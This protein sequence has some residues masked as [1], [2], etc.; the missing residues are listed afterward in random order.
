[1]DSKIKMK[2]ERLKVNGIAFCAI[3]L[4]FFAGCT[5]N[6]W[7]D[8]KLQNELWLEHNKT[9]PGVQVSSTG[10][11]YKIIADPLANNGEAKPNYNSTIICD[12]KLRL[13]NY[14][15][16]VYLQEAYGVSIPLANTVPG[17]S[18][19]CRKIHN[20]GDI[21]IYVPAYLGYDYEKYNSDNYNE[22][23]GSGTEGTQGYIPPY[24]TLIFS[25]HLCGISSN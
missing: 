24:S 25:V 23:E 20:H 21:E 18:E 9:L 12:Y 2:G 10:L 7:V 14:Q 11:Q 6:N 1:M 15:E 13:I 16:D 8:W 22:A 17:F 3:V 19:G 4:F 5:E